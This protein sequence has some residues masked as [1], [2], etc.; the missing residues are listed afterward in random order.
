MD[1]WWDCDVLDEMFYRAIRAR[2]EKSLSLNWRSLV[3]IAGTVLLNRQTRRRATAVVEQH[4]DLGNDFFE[5]ILDP[6]LQYT[7][8]YFEGTTDLAEAQRRKMDLICRKLNLAPD[9]RVLDIGCGWGGFAKFAAE[10]YGCRVVGITI[11]NEQHAYAQNLCRGLPV[12]IRL[13][14]Y[15][16]LSDKFDRAVAAGMVEHVGYKNY[17]NFMRTVSRSLNDDGLFLCQAISTS[18]SHRH[19]DPWIVRYIFPNSMLPS[20]AYLTKAA[21]GYFVLEDIQNFGVYY[22]PTLMA[23]DEKFRASWERFRSQY[24]ERFYR[25]WRYY[26]LSCAGA[27]RARGLQLYHFVFSKNGVP[28]GYRPPQRMGRAGFEPAKA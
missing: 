5:A 4:Y 3:A 20:A 15:R 16:D 11:S 12:E 18:I 22:D 21:E 28:G 17:R 1:G 27:F 14:D 25:M 19:P 10:N 26:L 2:L 13:Q 24:G 8:A 7:C 9:L 6:A 23:W